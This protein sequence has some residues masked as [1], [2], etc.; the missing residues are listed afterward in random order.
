MA[1]MRTKTAH[2]H[3]IRT[4]GVM[5]GEPRIA[6]H[7]IRVRDIVAARDLGGLAPLL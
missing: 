1:E 4:P 3:I 6:G 7:R 2:F 5:S